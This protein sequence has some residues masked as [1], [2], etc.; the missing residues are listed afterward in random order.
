MISGHGVA[1][2]AFPFALILDGGYGGSEWGQLLGWYQQR[3]FAR[4]CIKGIKLGHTFLIPQNVGDLGSIRAP[5]D[6]LWLPAGKA[7]FSK[8]RRNGEFL[9]DG[10]R[11]LS[12]QHPG[13]EKKKSG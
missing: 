1:R 10:R 8:N 11:R 2:A 12:K 6:G 9:G 4:G 5:L 3:G 7:I 13:Q